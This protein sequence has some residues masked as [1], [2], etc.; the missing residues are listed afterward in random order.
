MSNYPALFP[1]PETIRASGDLETKTALVIDSLEAAGVLTGR[2]QITAVLIRKLARAVDKGLAEPRVSVATTH[3]VR[4]LV[5]ALASLPQSVAGTSE[6]WDR[7]L[8][9]LAAQK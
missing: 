6:S 3:I 8:A 4:E 9:E 7:L 2:H 5:E 1:H